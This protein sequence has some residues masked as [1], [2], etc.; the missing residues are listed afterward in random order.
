MLNISPAK[1]RLPIHN[2]KLIK[3][4]CNKAKCKTSKTRMNTIDSNGLVI[5]C[6][7][8]I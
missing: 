6:Y 8:L 7:L 1:G 5:Y 4:M 2:F 3:E